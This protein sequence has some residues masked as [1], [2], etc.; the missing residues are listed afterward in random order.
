MKY[1][2]LEDRVCGGFVILDELGGQVYRCKTHLGAEKVLFEICLRKTGI[3]C[4]S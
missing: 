1:V 2:I 4:G 3:L